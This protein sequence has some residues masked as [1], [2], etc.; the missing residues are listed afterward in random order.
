[1]EKQNQAGKPA[2]VTGNQQTSEKPQI[3]DKVKQVEQMLTEQIKK[4][5]NLHEKITLRSK[6][7]TLKNQLNEVLSDTK[8]ED[9]NV[10]DGNDFGKIA[11][12][13][14]TSYREDAILTVKNPLLVTETIT[15]MLAK[16]DEKIAA[17]EAE[18]L[19]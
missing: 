7:M 6:F 2:Q 5:N 8:N 10:F 1:M 11:F 13:R 14:S 4:A 15:F 12:Y 9:A 19:G 16:I 18:I 17:L 3:V